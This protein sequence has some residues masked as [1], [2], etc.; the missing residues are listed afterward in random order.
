[1]KVFISDIISIKDRYD[2][3]DYYHLIGKIQSGLKIKIKDIF[4]D[5]R[6][7]NGFNVEMLLMVTRDPY[8]EL[9]KGIYSQLF[10]PEK[11]YSFEFI[12]ELKRRKLL[13][14]R[15]NWGS[16]ILTGEYIDPYTIPENWVSLIKP[17]AYKVMLEEPT[18]LKTEDGIYLISPLHS[19][20]RVPIEEFPQKV[21]IA[22]KSIN[23]AAWYPI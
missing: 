18:A 1:M 17:N 13:K 3:P 5:L 10:L 8:L 2:G 6:S 11:Y 9:E 21:S 7:Y 4:Y 15:S 19:R 22:S 16:V 20:K 12:N 23:L 14:S